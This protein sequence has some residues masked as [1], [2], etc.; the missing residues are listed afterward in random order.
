M[1]NLH[2]F[3]L[4][5]FLGSSLTTLFTML[6]IRNG[7]TLHTADANIGISITAVIIELLLLVQY[8]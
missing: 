7:F 6:M 3:V 2:K 5:F 4:T 1:K 8:K